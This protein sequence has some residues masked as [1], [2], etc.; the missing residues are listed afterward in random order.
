M[1]K[2]ES[3]PSLEFKAL[4]PAYQ[5]IRKRAAAKTSIGMA[6]GETGL[7]FV[8]ACMRCLRTTGWMNFRMRAMLVAVASYHVARLAGHG[9]V[10]GLSFHGL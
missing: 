10:S 3:E 8:D 6:K 7:P 2:L 1:Q 5:N 9:K 4:H